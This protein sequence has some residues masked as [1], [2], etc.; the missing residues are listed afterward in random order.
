V[1]IYLNIHDYFDK[2]GFNDGDQFL[3][4]VAK[5]AASAVIDAVN[6][7][8][9]DFAPEG[10]S[11]PSMILIE[12]PTLHNGVRAQIRWFA[13]GIPCVWDGKMENDWIQKALKAGQVELDF[14]VENL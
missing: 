7:A 13:N 12:F 11:E 14:F 5:R 10:V 3:C 6:E 1:K 8:L 2:H 9:E 4:A